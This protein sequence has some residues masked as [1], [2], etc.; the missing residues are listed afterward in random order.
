MPLRKGQTNPVVITGVFQGPFR[1]LGPTNSTRT[2]AFTAAS[3]LN[4]HSGEPVTSVVGSG[5]ASGDQFV[6]PPINTVRVQF[7]PMGAGGAGAFGQFQFIGE[8]EIEASGVD[9]S[10]WQR[11]PLGKVWGTLNAN[12]VGA[13]M[14][15]ASGT[16][17][18]DSLTILEDN[19]PGSGMRLATNTTGGAGTVVFDLMSNERLAIEPLCAVPSGQSGSGATSLNGLIAEY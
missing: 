13:G 14:P 7:C 5:A 3:G 19:T 17:Y 10:Y 18:M 2:A 6:A 9:G 12:I 15:I 8:K 1:P 16:R 4:I 11:R